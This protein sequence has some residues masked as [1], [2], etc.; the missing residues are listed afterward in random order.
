MRPVPLFND[1]KLLTKETA[2]TKER[3]GRVPKVFIS[4]DQDKVITVDLQ[5]LMIEK[6]SPN[7]VIEITGSDHMVMFSKSVELSSSILQIADKY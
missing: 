2:V 3:N 1:L 6:S 7:E 5:R 4:C